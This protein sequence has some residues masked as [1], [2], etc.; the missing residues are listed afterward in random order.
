MKIDFKPHDP[1]IDFQPHDPCRDITNYYNIVY[2]DNKENT[3]L[4][5]DMKAE[6]LNDLR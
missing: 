6:I 3:F 4:Q 1:K 5:R 2:I